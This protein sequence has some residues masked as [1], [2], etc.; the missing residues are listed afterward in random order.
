M[1]VPYTQ[2]EMKTFPNM[3]ALQYAVRAKSD[4]DT[5]TTGVREAVHAVDPDLPIANYAT[6]TTLVDTSTTADRFAMLLVAAF[7]ALVLV[8]AGIGMYGVISYS[9]LQRTPE[10]GVRI[11]LGAQRSQ[12]F[13]MVLKQG[14][15]L[16]CVGIAIGT[17]GALAATHLITRFLY[18]VQ[19]TDPVTFVAVSILLMAIALL[20]CYMPARKAMK[21]DP[22]ILLRYE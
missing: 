10:F 16:A 18:G 15:R 11:A 8:L 1:F 2:N 14:S 20:A 22:M 17:F 12:I 4:P 5:I 13:V 21:V 9:V 6:L 7:G 3:Q 19:P